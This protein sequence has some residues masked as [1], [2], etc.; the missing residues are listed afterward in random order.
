MNLTK[1]KLETAFFESNL[2]CYDAVPK[3]IANLT[4]GFYDASLSLIL[5]KFVFGVVCLA[6]F[7]MNL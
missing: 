3:T 4:D 5:W 6:A 2:M 1:F 7:L